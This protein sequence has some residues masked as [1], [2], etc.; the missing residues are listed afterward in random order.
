MTPKSIPKGKFLR[1]LQSIEQNDKNQRNQSP[2]AT[3]RKKQRNSPFGGSKLP[4]ETD[5]L[6]DSGV[7]NPD[8]GPFH[9]SKQGN[10]FL[11]IKKNKQR[12]QSIQYCGR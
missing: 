6:N 2:W 5:D 3:R 11:K 7:D 9:S 1:N 10:L 12:F 4:N 8:L